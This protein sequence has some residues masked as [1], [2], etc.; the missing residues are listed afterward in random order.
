ME[1]EGETPARKSG[2]VTAVCGGLP[3]EY[4]NCHT[5]VRQTYRPIAALFEKDLPFALFFGI[6]GQ[7]S[8]KV[9]KQI[10]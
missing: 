4:D 5:L 7:N 10:Q 9:Y 8:H 6:N 2:R 1:R 3:A